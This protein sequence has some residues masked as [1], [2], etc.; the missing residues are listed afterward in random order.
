MPFQ[1]DIPRDWIIEAEA[2]EWAAVLGI[3]GAIAIGLY[4]WNASIRRRSTGQGLPSWGRWGMG[5]LRFAALAILGFLLLEPLIRSIEFDEEKPV[6]ILLM[7]ESESVLVRADSAAAGTLRSWAD[8]ACK[9][10]ASENIVVERYGFG[11]ELRPLESTLDSTFAWTGAQTNL[12]NAVRSLAPRL[13]NRNIAGVLLASDGLINRGASPIYGVQWPNLPVHTVGLG[14]TTSV[15]DRWIHRVNHNT[16][17]YLGNAFPLQAFVESQGLAN[18]GGR[19]QIIHDGATVASE[20]WTTEGEFERTKFDFMLPAESIGLQRYTVRVATLDGE[21]DSTNNSRTVYIEVLESRRIVA[22]IGAA[23]HPDIGALRTALEAMESYEL[24]LF[25]LSTLKNPNALTDALNKADV[26]IAHNLLGKRWGGMEWTKLFAMNDLPVWWWASDETTWSHLQ[27]NNDLGVQLT[28]SGDLNQ[29]HRARLN[30][31]FSL[32]EWPEEVPEAI[33]EWPPFLG[34]FEQATWSPAW[35]PLL[36]RQFGDVQTQD[37][38]WGL[39]GSASGSKQILT[40]GEGLWRWRMRNYALEQ[41]HG[42]FDT[43]IQRQVQF[44]TAEDARQRL[45]VQT[46][47]RI[48]A[49]QRMVFTAQAYDAAWTPLRDATIELTL[50][51]DSG[52]SFAQTMLTTASGYAA[53]FGR[54]QAGTYRWK[55]VS[56]LDGAVF[57]ASGLVIVDDTQIERAQ[58]AADHNTVQRIAAS[59]GGIHLG[60]WRSA[61][62]Q[63]VRQAFIQDGLPAVVRHEQTNLREAIDWPF[64]L[65]LA[66]VLLSIEWVIRRRNLGY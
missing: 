61:D 66:I 14:D 6:A 25:D 1:I 37:A 50:T 3:A 23:A 18:Q 7:D 46:E 60:D 12:D 33:R 56:E 10:L 20:S 32:L 45:T 22:C 8:A 16:V 30:P 31:G 48:G 34:P 47:K 5:I 51:D 42:N 13:E 41:R 9:A 38:F 11:G 49:D 53:D 29:T 58:R 35:S 28:Q 52:E 64:W 15:R 4:G 26:V 54:M 59:T 2:W 57:D 40:I 63:A 27:S 44:L 24:Q 55:A 43:F 39:R 21:Y 36:F 62:A 17:A 65:V 19:I